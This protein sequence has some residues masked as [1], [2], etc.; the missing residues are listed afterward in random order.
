M[1]IGVR[2][3][4]AMLY[5]TEVAREPKKKRGL[6]SRTR[7]LLASME[8]KGYALLLRKPKAFLKPSAMQP[9]EYATFDPGEENS[10]VARQKI[11][12]R[13][14]SRIKGRR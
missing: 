12:D 6:R 11:T 7:R 3:T 2:Q 9:E 1:T 13:P 10:K 14:L 8:P 5:D 4:L